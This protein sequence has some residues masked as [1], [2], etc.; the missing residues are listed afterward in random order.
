[1]DS[2]VWR[3]LDFHVDRPWENRRFA[4]L[5][6]KDVMT[7]ASGPS[8]PITL[9]LKWNDHSA[10][11]LKARI[12]RLRMIDRPI[13]LDGRL[14][15]IQFLRGIPW[16]AAF[17]LQAFYDVQGSHAMSRDIAQPY[18]KR[19]NA[20][21][22]DHSGLSTIS[23]ACR[24]IFD[25]R[26]KGMTGRR[27]AIISDPLVAEVAAFWSEYSGR[28]I[29]D[30]SKALIFLREIFKRCAREPRELING[31]SFLE[32]RIGLV[33]HHAD[34]QATHISLEPFLF[35]TSDLIHIVAAISVV[36]A[37]VSDFDGPK[38]APRYFDGVDEAAWQTLQADHSGLLS[39]RLFQD[40]DI[41]VQS[42]LYWKVPE[43][44]GMD[45]LLNT[46]PAAL[47]C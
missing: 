31:A 1:M 45:M 22:R 12:D 43:F 5:Y 35:G 29:E 11:N 42:E 16:R 8:E 18:H 34:R 7:E 3:V 32:Q 33:R 30:A 36:G 23:L 4:E 39:Q 24:A 28:P 10:A 44:N 46:L 19:L 9:T 40:F 6:G 27:F 17:A 20:A 37:I 13:A 21:F 2:V 47:G 14:K 41:H 15:T 25:C 38:R 26:M